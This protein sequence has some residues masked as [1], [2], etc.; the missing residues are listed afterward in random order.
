MLS[1]VAVD[2]APPHTPSQPGRPLLNKQTKRLNAGNF[3][4]TRMYLFRLP[5]RRVKEH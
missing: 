5:Q 1:E 4:S 2:N 3:R